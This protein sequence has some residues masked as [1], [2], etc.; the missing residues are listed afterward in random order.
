MTNQNFMEFFKKNSNNKFPFNLSNDLNNEIS[1]EE[2]LTK[3]FE[4]NN[5]YLVAKNNKN[6]PPVYFY[7]GLVENN[8]PYVFEV[9]F[10]KGKIYFIFLIFLIF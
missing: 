2:S 5:I 1:N 9:S 6:D 10:V 7:S 3:I 4:K 8:L